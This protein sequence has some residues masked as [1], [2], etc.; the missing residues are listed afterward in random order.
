MIKIQIASNTPF[1]SVS[2]EGTLNLV[3]SLSTFISSSA[4]VK[5]PGDNS[6]CLTVR[7]KIERELSHPF[8]EMKMILL[9]HSM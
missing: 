5:S 2:G 7:W 9:I 3:S 6:S 8:A 4:F 1:I